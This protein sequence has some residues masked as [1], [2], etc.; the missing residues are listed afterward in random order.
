MCIY[1]YLWQA[2][3]QQT[4]ITWIY[5]PYIIYHIFLHMQSS[6]PGVGK[7]SVAK[8]V[9]RALNKP[10]YRFSVGGLG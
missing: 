5:A 10:F 1:S 9:A 2:R 8:S 4:L 6:P 7:T 3:I